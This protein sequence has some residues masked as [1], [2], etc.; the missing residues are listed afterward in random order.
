MAESHILQ[1]EFPSH[2]HANLDF[3]TDTVHQMEMAVGE[4]DGEGDSRKSASRPQ[5]HN[6]SAGFETSEFGNSQ[7]MQ[8]MMFIQIVDVF[9]GNDIDFSIP[10]MIEHIQLTELFCL[11]FRKFRKVF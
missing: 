8:Y 9:P 5:I 2:F 10:I 6:L 7:G 11:F 4:H 1:P 3:L